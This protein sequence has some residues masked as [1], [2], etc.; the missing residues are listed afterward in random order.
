MGTGDNSLAALG[1][2]RGMAGQVCHRALGEAEMTAAL[3]V[4]LLGRA[5]QRG[6]YTIET[7]RK[8]C[9]P[10]RSETGGGTRRRRVVPVDDRPAIR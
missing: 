2:R 8:S 6:V 1:S 7:L 4:E 5:R 9:E 10:G 3:W